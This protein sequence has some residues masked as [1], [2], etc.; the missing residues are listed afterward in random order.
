M[1]IFEFNALSYEGKMKAT[2]Q[3]GYIAT[4]EDDTHTIILYQLESFYIEVFFHRHHHFI[5]VFRGIEDIN[6]PKPFLQMS[7]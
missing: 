5:S 7:S 4:M 1:T 2:K 6:I 3:A